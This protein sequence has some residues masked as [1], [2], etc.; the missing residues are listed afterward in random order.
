[1]KLKN[2]TKYIIAA[3]L[4]LGVCYMIYRSASDGFSRTKTSFT[5]NT[6]TSITAYGVSAEDA[7]QSASLSVSEVEKNFSAYV[8]TSEVSALNRVQTKDTP[9]HVSDELFEIL[10]TA[11]RYSELTG[12][13]FDVTIKPVS[14]LWS[15]SENPRVPSYGEISNALGRVGYQNMV[16]DEENKTV[17]F[18]LDGMQ[19]DLGGIAKGYAADR[20]AERI[21]NYDCR[22]ALI[23]LGGN[24][25]VL[26]DNISPLTGFAN[27]YL[28][29]SIQKPWRVGIQTPFAPSGSYCAV[30]S[31]LCGTDEAVNIVTSG[32]YERNFTQ[33][34]TLY[35]HILDP[36]SGYP[37]N[38]EIDSVTIIGPR[39]ADADALSTSAY[40][41]SV[42]AALSL[43]QS[44]GY[45]AI[46][47]GKDK[48]I[49]TT[50][51]KGSVE[52]TDSQ[53]SFAD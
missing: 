39:S 17:T 52:I 15:I 1:M 10:K 24:V 18:L 48:K 47:I 30:I 36:R 35:H 50:L 2:L 53:Y 42:D 40:M 5:M 14:D 9:I 11:R 19:I 44:C 51:D 38:G 45:D 16:L 31:V 23:N 20:A 25:C 41:L 13:L 8:D 22:K 26:G 12:G 49:H 32:A 37:Y 3:M 43:V 6:Y 4:V 21:R 27:S 34:G 29:F 28:G 7:S 46:I 33:D